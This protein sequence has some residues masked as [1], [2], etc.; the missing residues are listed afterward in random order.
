M[1]PV[2][3]LLI[4]LR[5]ESTKPISSSTSVAMADAKLKDALHSKLK[6]M[7]HCKGQAECS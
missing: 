2:R 4:D 5:E 1:K 7:F 3:K 6:D